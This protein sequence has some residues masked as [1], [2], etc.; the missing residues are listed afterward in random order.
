MKVLLSPVLLALLFCSSSFAQT[1]EFTYQGKLVDSSL[2]A[3]GNYDLRFALYDSASG[4]SQIGTTITRPSVPVTN[5]IFT[6][7]LDFLAA[8][9]FDGSPRWIEI[10][11]RRTGDPTFTLLGP[12][13]PLA[14]VPYSVRSI[15]SSASDIAGNSLQ[16][17]G[18]N[19]DQFVVTSDPRMT[20]GRAPL[21]NSSNYIQNRT[22]SAQPSANFDISGS[23]FVRGNLLV[24]GTL[25]AVLG[26]TGQSA[27]G[28]SQL[29]LPGGSSTPTL[30]PGLSLT[31]TAP[32]NGFVL[33]STSGG[34]QTTSLSATG[35]SIVDIGIYVDGVIP[36]NGVIQR[37]LVTNNNALTQQWVYWNVS[38]LLFLTYPGTHTIE[39]KAVNSTITSATA[40]ISGDSSTVLQGRLSIAVIKTVAN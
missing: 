4:G 6:V 10:F 1:T 15:T 30:V 13:Q 29:Q 32:S 26:Q 38:D 11:V 40:N 33:V 3:A 24:G 25:N 20:D 2:P 9:S 28:T 23:G 7:Q 34:I 36:P 31:V 14:S 5:G 8:A 35:F 18:V 12:R 22:G 21:P 37:H 39:I 27:S 16:L 17:G 19:A